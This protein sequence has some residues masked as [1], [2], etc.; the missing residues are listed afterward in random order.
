M[1]L[2]GFNAFEYRGDT[3]HCEGVSLAAI[4]DSVG[5]PVYVYSRNAIEGAYKA[6]DAALAGIDHLICYSVKAN[7]S[8]GI[9]NVLARLGAGADIVSGGELFRWLKAGGD[10]GKVVFSGVGKTE[11]E[12]R[13]ALESGI[14]AFNV[15]STEEI[16]VLDR[17]ARA[18]GVKARVA[19]RINPD[20]DAQTH[21]YISTGL[22]Q[23][24]FGIAAAAA[25]D[26]FRRAA[27]LPNLDVR[28][29][30]CHIG[31]QLTKTSPFS[32]AIT[33]LCDLILSLAQEGIQITDLDIGG[34]L[35]IDYGKEG[36]APPPSHGE[37]GAAVKQAMAMLGSH[38]I[39]L[40]VE[41][42]RS[43]VGPAGVLLGRVVYNKDNEVKHFTIVDAAMNDLIR[44][45]FYGSHHPMTPV[46]RS[47]AA[48]RKTDIV[49]P[50]CETGDFL[51]RD[52]ALPPMARGELLAIGAAGAYGFTMSSNY[53]TRPR[54]AEVLVHGDRYTVIRERETLEHL[55]RGERT[56][57]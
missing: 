23:N 45:S 36:D 17:V 15:E 1:S 57:E 27:S 19:L 8:I 2:A 41:P 16:E 46:T 48:P 7:S 55:V 50:I 33:R 51:A 3:L 25:R 14:L 20:V 12:M 9:L 49:G 4:A 39:R 44:P 54:A 31:S 24:K 22:T 52:R 37:Y 29:I 5:T 6:Y 26:A 28:G 40:L 18:A 32:D 11:A 38:P 47:E 30:D 13:T 56:A 53:N 10:A 34:G 35:G 42:G 21:P 43:I